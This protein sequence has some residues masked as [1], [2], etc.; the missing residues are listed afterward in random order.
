MARGSRS[1]IVRAARARAGPAAAEAAALTGRHL[2]VMGY[3]LVRGVGTPVARRVTGGP[4]G[5]SVV[6][7]LVA[8]LVALLTGLGQPGLPG[9]P[10]PVPPL[11]VK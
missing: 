4:A 2:E 3:P 1:G 9:L 7:D 5:S 10:L 6:T 8:A 11:P